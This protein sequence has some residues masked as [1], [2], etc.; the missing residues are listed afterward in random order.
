M[1]SSASTTAVRTSLADVVSVV[2]S[3]CGQTDPALLSGAQ[4]ASG[5]EQLAVVIRQLTAMQAGL[6]ARV[7]DC[8]S[9]PKQSGS[10]R[11]WLA[12]LNGSSVGEAKRTLDT[13]RRLKQCPAT[14]DAF[15]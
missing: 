12:R 8:H 6:A 1:T 15:A 9:H 3:W 10:S 2:G 11:D 13:A 7:E 14:A 5:V 4:A